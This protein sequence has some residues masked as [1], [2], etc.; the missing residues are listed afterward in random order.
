MSQD[1]ENKFGIDLA[2]EG[3]D[4]TIVTILKLTDSQKWL[5]LKSLTN[6]TE[7]E[8]IERLL[9]EFPECDTKELEKDLKDILGQ[10]NPC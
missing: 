1:I 3:K 5:V 9:E 2:V 6:F 7:I 8:N 4:Q 10:F